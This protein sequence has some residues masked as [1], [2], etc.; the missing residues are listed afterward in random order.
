MINSDSASLL[1]NIISKNYIKVVIRQG[2]LHLKSFSLY[3]L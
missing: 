1:E 3:Y 2:K